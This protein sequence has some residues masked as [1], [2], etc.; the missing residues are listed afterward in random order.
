LKE[1]IQCIYRKFVEVS[2]VIYKYIC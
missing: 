1:S 2:C